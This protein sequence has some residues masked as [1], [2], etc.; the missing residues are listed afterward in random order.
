MNAVG[1]N[2]QLSANRPPKD[3]S[4]KQL[5]LVMEA[6]YESKAFHD[7][8]CTELKQPTETMQQHFSVFLLKR[9]GVKSIAQEW[10]KT[11]F[12]AITRWGQQDCD[13]AVLGKILQNSLA[14]SFRKIQESLRSS[15][16][17]LLKKELQTQNKIQKQAEVDALWREK[18]QKGVPVAECETVVAHLYNEHDSAV[19]LHRVRRAAAEWAEQ[20]K[21]EPNSVRYRDLV[22]ILLRF[23]MDLTEGFFS[24]FARTFEEVDQDEDGIVSQVEMDDLLNKLLVDINLISDNASVAARNTLNEAK[25]ELQTV[26]QTCRRATFSECADM[27]TGVVSARWAIIKD[28]RARAGIE[29]ARSPRH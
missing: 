11:I 8:R 7:K 4:L 10:E 16:L 17:T 14:E 22:Q 26:I 1:N 23:Q 5:K 19:V 21:A 29:N 18:S 2:A 20:P 27:F 25:L 6:L 9:Y 15:V 13:V 3:L 12:R 28:M 24:D